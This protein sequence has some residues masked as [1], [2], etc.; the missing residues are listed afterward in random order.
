GQPAP[1]ILAVTHSIYNRLGGRESGER[2][3]GR[4]VRNRPFTGRHS[5]FSPYKGAYQT[6]WTR[7][8]FG[9]VHWKR[10]EDQNFNRYLCS[11]DSSG[12]RAAVDLLCRLRDCGHHVAGPRPAH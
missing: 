7:L 6:S 11:V 3:A 9:E 1:A 10:Q 12:F 5:V 4:I 8:N 2:L